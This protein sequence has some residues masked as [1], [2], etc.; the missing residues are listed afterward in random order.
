MHISWAPAFR[1]LQRPQTVPI[2]T[3]SNLEDFPV[4]TIKRT[5]LS[6]AAILAA[7]ALAG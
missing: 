3:I 6:T 2:P 5:A 4:L 7:L 1:A